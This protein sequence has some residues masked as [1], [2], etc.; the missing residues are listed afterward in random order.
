MV[1]GRGSGEAPNMSSALSPARGVASREIHAQSV[2]TPR[3][4]KPYAA[5][6]DSGIEWLGEIPA[7][8]EVKPL[9]H[10]T[11]FSTGWTPP[12]GREDLYGG[13]HLWA[14]I[15][16]LGSKVITTTE[17]TITDKAVRE[18]R[19]GIVRPGSLL[20]SFKLSV[21]AVSIAG[22]DMYTNEAIAAF[23]PSPRIDTTYLYWAAPVLV[24][25]NAQQNIYGAPLLNRERIANAQL[26]SPPV[27]EQ[28]AI[29]AFLDRETARI[30]R[31]LA[32]KER[33]I[34]LLQEQHAA[35]IESALRAT[36]D[37]DSPQIRLAYYVDLLPGYA[38]PSDGFSHDLDDVR[39][40]RGI[41]ISPD[42]IHWDDT[43]L[44]P[45]AESGRY[46]SYQLRDGDLVFGM[47]RPWISSGIRVAEVSR[48]DVPSLLLQ[49]VAR[50][51]ARTGLSQKYLRLVLSSP[52]FRAYFEPILT[53]VSVPHVSPEQILSFRISLPSLQ[54][55]E[56]IW[57]RVQTQTNHIKSMCH[58]LRQSIARVT[59]LRTALISAAVT[60]KIDVREEAAA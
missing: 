36:E 45:A 18:A 28:R 8:W 13:D 53:G 9:K 50:L 29:A 34:E 60:G 19:L 11:A 32:K 33:L 22:T 43:V 54:V 12:T 25:H 21:G 20:F 41:N 1:I 23:S 37:H 55:Q 38:F 35:A 14:S 4:F 51:R 26:L 40:L 16:D 58:S 10:L 3:R 42:G 39:L 48:S 30:D 24:P 44:W 7:H 49:R 17:K 47:D 52:Q 57:Q 56:T 6:K 15:S 31:L 5:Y 59:E 27:P 46:R 2:A